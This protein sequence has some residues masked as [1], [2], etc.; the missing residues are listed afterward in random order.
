MTA[1]TAKPARVF[2]YGTLMPG[3]RN[4]QVARTHGFPTA[5]PATLHGYRL[6]HLTPENYPGIVPGEQ[7]D[8]VHGYLLTYR[9]DTWEKVLPLLDELEGLDETPPLYTRAQV[10]LETGG[11]KENAWV[12]VY[13]RAERLQGPGAQ[14][15]PSGDWRETQAREQHGPD[16]R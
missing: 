5:Q 7:L 8:R 9:D 2:V 16:E 10:Q 12:Y 15:I 1:N 4:E 11:K 13:A 6:F 14:F 3:E